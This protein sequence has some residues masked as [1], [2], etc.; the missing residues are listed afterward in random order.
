MDER[1]VIVLIDTDSLYYKTSKESVEDSILAFDIMFRNIILETKASYYMAFNSN[2]PYF[3]HKIDPQYKGQRGKYPTKLKW[4]KTL[5]RY[6]E[7]MY[8]VINVKG[9]EADDL[10]AYWN[11]FKND[12]RV[13]DIVI[14]ESGEAVTAL[15]TPIIASGDKDVLNLPGRSF[16]LNDWKFVDTTVEESQDFLAY[17][18]LCG[19]ASDNI[20]GCG[21]REE[22]TYKSGEKKGE[23]YLRRSGITPKVAKAFIEA[24]KEDRLL[25]IPR[26]LQ[27]YIE[28]FGEAMGVRRFSDT[29]RMIRM[30]D[31]D[32]SY[33]YEGLSVM[34]ISIH[35]V[36][37]LVTNIKTDE[38]DDEQI[39][40]V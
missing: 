12:S 25:M 29:Y 6:S 4:T 9:A 27:Y 20:L 38:I 32:D 19:D 18:L 16:N 39:S 17:Q 14:N 26:V 7:E 23:K 33:A 10:V 28:A 40:Q 31:D 8:G 1:K 13:T 30:L 21:V 35:S 36:Q 3:R 15:L 37:E 24:Y 22:A 5:K 11:N 34:P 2:T